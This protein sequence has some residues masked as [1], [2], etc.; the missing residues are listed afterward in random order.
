MGRFRGAAEAALKRVGDG[1]EPKL[2]LSRT[3]AKAEA[4]GDKSLFARA[5]KIA[6]RTGHDVLTPVGQFLQVIDLPRSAVV[7]TAEETGRAL[8]GDGFSIDNLIKHTKAHRGVGQVITEENPEFASGLD[9]L[10]GKGL[11][12]ATLGSWEAPE[13]GSRGVA[14]SLVVSVTWLSIP[15]T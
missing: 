15:S 10:A 4:T 12:L 5:R 9:R 6:G 3:V 7:S 2:R 8:R 1:D 11:E 13:Q 14:V